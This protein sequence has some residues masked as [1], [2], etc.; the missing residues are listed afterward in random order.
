MALTILRLFWAAVW[1]GSHQN[2]TDDF[3]RAGAGIAI[4][5]TA[6]GGAGAGQYLEYIMNVAQATS[7]SRLFSSAGV[8][9]GTGT[10]VAAYLMTKKHGDQRVRHDQARHGL[11]R[12]DFCLRSSLSVHR[13]DYAQSSADA[14]RNVCR[15]WRLHRAVIGGYIV[16]AM[17]PHDAWTDGTPPKPARHHKYHAVNRGEG[18]PGLMA[19]FL[20]RQNLIRSTQTRGKTGD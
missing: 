14:A 18:K 4:G 19:G 16:D 13:N 2:E 15:R 5:A 6:T 3:C 12:H 8:G 17:L 7:R 11:W 9:V 10:D 1:R 20:L